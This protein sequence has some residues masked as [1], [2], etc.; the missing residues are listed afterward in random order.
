MEWKVKVIMKK[1]VIILA[2]MCCVMGTNAQ[3][4]NEGEAS[5]VYYMPKNALQVKICYT[6]TTYQAGPY[7]EFAKELLGIDNA[8]QRNETHYELTK[9]TVRTTTVP[10]FSRPVV[11]KAQANMP[12]QLLSLTKEGLLAGYNFTPHKEC[13]E[14]F[15]PKDGQHM[16]PPCHEVKAKASIPEEV[17]R[18][19]S[20]REKAELLAKQIYRLRETR[21]YLLSGEVDKMPADGEA[22]K[23]VLRQLEAEEKGLT[24]LFIGTV[25]TQSKSR[26][27]TY[28]P[29]EN[30]SDTLCRFS[31][32][33]GLIDKEDE[34]GESVVLKA[35]VRMMNLT[36]ALNVGMMNWEEGKKGGKAERRQATANRQQEEVQVSPILYNIPGWVDYEIVYG[37]KCLTKKSTPIAQF[38]VS[39]PLATNLFTGKVLPQIE[40]DTQTGNIKT[41]HL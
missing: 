18:A 5:V 7:K 32:T 4:V 38:G 3:V 39:V 35:Q 9:T 27:F 40:F 30:K 24:E 16:L 29:T 10:D 37:I 26:H 15:A 31:E 34:V 1:I 11:V 14:P 20:K 17:V 23:E 36:A 12:F 6:A 19:Y 13:K 8:I 33:D 41:I 28:E 21:I 2:A 22:T 25:S